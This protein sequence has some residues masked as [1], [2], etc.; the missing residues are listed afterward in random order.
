MADATTPAVTPGWKTTE[1]WKS[2]V[3]TLFGLLMAA[4]VV[5]STGIWG[6]IAGL[7]AST[8]AS[9]GYSASRAQVKTAAIEQGT[10]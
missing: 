2:A 8:L 9:T 4:G 6:Q 1:F 10:A 3:V 7:V 5:P